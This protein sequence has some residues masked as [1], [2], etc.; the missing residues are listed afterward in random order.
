MPDVAE[1]AR[2]VFVV[3]DEPEVLTAFSTELR[4]GGISNVAT[5]SDPREVLPKLAATG[6][7]AVLLDLMM[8]HVRGQDL[9][10]QIVGAYPEIPVIV[11]TAAAEVGTAVECMK[12]GAYDY[13]TKPLEEGRLVTCVR[14]ALAHRQ[15]QRELNALR[16]GLL[17]DTL[18]HPE[19]FA[20]MFTG[21]KSM[22]AV[23]RYI[24]LV[25]PSPQALLITGE[26]GV[27]KQ[28]VA[29]AAHS[30][31]G[32]TGKFVRVNVAGLDDQVFAD[33][34]FGHVKGAFTG[35]DGARG[36]MVETAAG[37]TLFLDEIG[38]LSPVSQVK[39]LNLIQ[40]GEYLPLGRD[41]PSRSDAR[42]MAATSTNV[43]EACEAGRF[44]RD[45]YYRLRT[46]H[47]HVP[48]LRERPDDLPG[49]VDRFLQEAAVEQ[50]KKTPTVPRELFQLLGAY[51]FPGN[52]RE[53]RAMVFDAVGRHEG[54]VLSTAAF[55]AGIQAAGGAPAGEQAPTPDAGTDS[56][57]AGFEKLPALAE[58]GEQLVQEALRRADGNLSVAADTL[59]I[60]RQALSKRLKRRER[61]A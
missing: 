49:L 36:G 15:M 3:D 11:V 4:L 39:L 61:P 30:L 35:A 6:A 46:H 27:G 43:A 47:V 13:L 55:K 5:C 14:H 56:L 22:L 45:L 28:L 38:D 19:A 60:S 2:P 51:H 42:I 54:G 40:E 33:T 20:A 29:Q 37:G 48:P 10:A 44:R 8:P 53:L 18:Q 26:T 1:P 32:R 23:F 57:F 7:E 24:E 59:G 9:L 50:G 12:A 17:A 58:A 16:E 25:A 31:S 52:V 21:E 41:V 34:L